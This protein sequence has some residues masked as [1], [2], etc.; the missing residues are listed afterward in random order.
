LARCG[1]PRA[2]CVTVVPAIDCAPTS[3]APAADAPT[4]VVVVA[5]DHEA[6][7]EGEAGWGLVSADPGDACGPVAVGRAGARD[8]DP[9]GVAIDG[10]GG[11]DT[12]G[13]VRPPTVTE[14]TFTEGSVI[15][16]LASGSTA[17]SDEA[18]STA[19]A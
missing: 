12:E 10:S 13:V 2:T 1:E 15:A 11:V 4:T 8:P 9:I 17:S 19:A 7:P 6:A 3:P 14:G 5:V 16:L 18:L